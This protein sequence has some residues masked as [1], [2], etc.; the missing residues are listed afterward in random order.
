M[1]HNFTLK[2]FNT[3]WMASCRAWNQPSGNVAAEKKKKYLRGCERES[4]CHGD[5]VADGPGGLDVGFYG[6]QDVRWG[7]E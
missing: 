5:A 2:C 7:V 3:T 4:G 6:P 1:C